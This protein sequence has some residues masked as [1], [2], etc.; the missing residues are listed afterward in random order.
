MGTP[1]FHPVVA[2]KI[3][4][5]RKLFAVAGIDT[6]NLTTYPDMDGKYFRM[7][8]IFDQAGPI[9]KQILRLLTL[10]WVAKI[11]DDYLPNELAEHLEKIKEIY[12]E[13]EL[14]D[15][16]VKAMKN[17]I[18]YSNPDLI[19]EDIYRLRQELHRLILS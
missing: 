6:E 3:E 14:L 10:P 7:L 17:G 13:L 12:T 8:R 19:L 11:Q 4:V 1:S 16:G 9:T 5:Y 15:S 18:V 2:K